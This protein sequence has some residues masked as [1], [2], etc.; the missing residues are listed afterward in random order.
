M[1]YK[2]RDVELEAI[3]QDWP[4]E[5]REPVSM[6]EISTGAPIYPPEDPMHKEKSHHDSDQ[7]SLMV[8]PI[9]SE[10]THIVAEIRTK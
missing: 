2:L 6:K 10:A 5:S 7:D 3:V 4:I 9:D 8:I 1:P